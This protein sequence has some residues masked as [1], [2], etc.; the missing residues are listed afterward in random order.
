VLLDFQRAEV[1]P[2]LVKAAERVDFAVAEKV[3]DEVTV[4]KRDDSGD[5]VGK[6]RQAAKIL[7][8]RGKWMTTSIPYSLELFVDQDHNW[9]I[10]T[11][12][13]PASRSSKAACRASRHTSRR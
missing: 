8:T 13:A 11:S 7:A 5:V 1:L 3:L 12:L 4:P 6:K 10:D 2:A 9:V